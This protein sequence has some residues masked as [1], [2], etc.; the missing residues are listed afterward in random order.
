MSAPPSSVLP[1]EPPAQVPA[2]RPS[3]RRTVLGLLVILAVSLGL[4]LGPID[5]GLPVNYVPDTHLV[6]SALGMARDKDP[7]PEVGAYSTYPNLLAYGLLPVY[8]V[9]YAGG[10]ATGAWGGAQ[11]FGFHALEHPE[12]VHLPARILFALLS[13]LL[14]LVAFGAARAMNLDVG[15]WVAAW[16]AATG[17]LGVHFSIQERPWEP[18]V[19]FMLLAT[20]PAARYVATE[21]RSALVLA[22]LAAA[23]SFGCHQAGG[24]ALL[25]PAVA[26]ALV[27]VRSRAELAAK[28]GRLVLDG[29]LAVAA[30]VALG[31]GVGHP[32][33]LVH[34]RTATDAVVMGEELE[35]AT[36]AISLGG[37]GFQPTF[38]L[39]SFEHLFAAMLSYDPVLV[40]M[41]LLGFFVC[42]RRRCIWPALAFIL[43]WGG[44]F[45]FSANDHV[46]YI[47]PLV[48][49]LCLPA[50]ALVER[51]HRRYGA[52]PVLQGLLGVVLLVPL[53]QAMR[54]AH[55]MAHPDV[56]AL[57]T[58]DLLVG[59][60]ALPE[61]ARLAVAR[62][63]PIL[64]RSLAS[65]EELARV[66][67]LYSRET[68]RKL[69]LEGLAEAG[70]PADHPEHGLPG[71]A[72]L[73]V[74]YLEDYLDFDDRAET[75][76]LRDGVLPE[77]ARDDFVGL[78][79][80]LGVTHVMLTDKTPGDG[81]LGLLDGRLGALELVRAWTPQ[82]LDPEVELAAG[83]DP[84]ALGRF[85]ARLPTELDQA[86]RTIWRVD[87]PGPV[88]AL[89]ERVP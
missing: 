28:A 63:A 88:L 18:M 87:R 22:C 50:G 10:R 85:E 16:L 34:G 19:L 45:L 53:V 76:A 62:Y 20:W 69:R 49:L 32:Y 70:L 59:D 51:L 57:A 14:P 8:A 40:V 11:E 43:A 35:Q 23:L 58:D 42:W 6:R 5:H 83:E 31:V 33:L 3:R 79:D 17:M 13:A 61:G 48:G 55:V 37:Q 80:L 68:H 86:G 4:R 27:F 65:L 60:T 72:G 71:G 64:P 84:R 7:V 39:E 21:K 66:R 47:L 26:W 9:Q 67:D 36:G 73:D 46:R 74:V 38:R 12:D 1:S 89:F 25:I 44:L 29:V 77:L 81:Q 54:F 78:L 56:R 24:A 30:F 2:E 75:V 52:P 82:G 41:G 15:A